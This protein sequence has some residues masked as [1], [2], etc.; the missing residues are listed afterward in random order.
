MYQVVCKGNLIGTFCPN[1]LDLEFFD[2][3]GKPGVVWNP[4]TKRPKKDGLALWAKTLDENSDADSE[5]DGLDP[6]RGDYSEQEGEDAEE[7]PEVDDSG[8]SD[9]EGGPGGPDDFDEEH[10]VEEGEIE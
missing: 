10:P 9:L 6:H 7:A 4:F 2:G 3:D 8:R 5:S 1:V